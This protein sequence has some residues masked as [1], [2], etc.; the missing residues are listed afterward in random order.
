VHN[1]SLPYC[2]TSRHINACQKK[3][4]PETAKPFQPGNIRRASQNMIKTVAKPA[5]NGKDENVIVVA[6]KVM[7]SFSTTRKPSGAL[8]SNNKG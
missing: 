8:W 2:F 5:K 7:D 6:E 1:T 3:E 4:E